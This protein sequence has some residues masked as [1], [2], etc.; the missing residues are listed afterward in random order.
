MRVPSGDQD[1]P[2]SS[3]GPSVA[4]AG[5]PDPSAA[6]TSTWVWRSTSHPTLSSRE[7]SCVMRR[8]GGAL[9]PRRAPSEARRHRGGR[10]CQRAQFP[11]PEPPLL[12][13]AGALP[14]AD[15]GLGGG[16]P[17]NG[18]PERGAAHVVEAG[19]V[20]QLDRLGIAAVLAA[21]A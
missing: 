13:L 14:S 12:R 18:H 1:R 15:D 2:A 7:K 20:E 11:P 3:K 6:T 5:G 8:G 4:W 19:L 16:Q 10:R 17:G 9:A 21:D